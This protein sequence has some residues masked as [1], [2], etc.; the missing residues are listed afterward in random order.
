VIELI[1]FSVQS[2][3]LMS[4][5]VVQLTITLSQDR[6]RHPGEHAC[7]DL[8]AAYVPIFCLSD[9]IPKMVGLDLRRKLVSF[10]LTSVAAYDSISSLMEHFLDV[11]LTRMY[12]PGPGQSRPAS[13]VTFTSSKLLKLR[14]H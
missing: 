10:S 7:I 5:T 13:S 8:T 3:L 4:K 6:I 14:C 1:Q 12:C 9:A 11:L 2:H